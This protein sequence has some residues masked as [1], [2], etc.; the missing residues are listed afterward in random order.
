MFKSFCVNIIKIYISC[1][2]FIFSIRKTVNKL[3]N[4]IDK[5][6]VE[7]FF[8]IFWKNFIFFLF[9]IL[10]QKKI[11]GPKQIYHLFECLYRPGDLLLLRLLLLRYF[12]FLWDF[13]FER[14]LFGDESL[15]LDD[16]DRD[17]DDLE[18]PDDEF[19][20]WK[21]IK[22]FFLII[23]KI[24]IVTAILNLNLRFKNW[25]LSNFKK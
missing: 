18:L 11:F 24:C 6:N 7:L 8:V 3:K 25:T 20:L 14:F 19:F 16:L 9:F 15:L 22:W 23:F 21:I 12:L 1:L 17:R 5:K 2:C 4:F 10:K 13:F